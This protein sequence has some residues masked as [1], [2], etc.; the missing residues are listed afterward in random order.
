MLTW[1]C[2]Y[3]I[4][5]GPYSNTGTAL[6]TCTSS[7]CALIQFVCSL[8]ENVPLRTGS[9]LSGTQKETEMRCKV[10]SA[11]SITGLV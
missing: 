2:A 11:G 7:C 4:P 5:C 9:K 10:A 8:L 3:K 6:V 1:K